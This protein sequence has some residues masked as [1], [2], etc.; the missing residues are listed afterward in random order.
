MFAREPILLAVQK[1]L[2]VRGG[3]HVATG[4]RQRR[5][6]D[7]YL[8]K[9]AQIHAFLGETRRRVQRRKWL[10]QDSTRQREARGA[11]GCDGMRRGGRGRAVRRSAAVQRR[12]A[13]TDTGSGPRTGR[14]G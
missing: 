6:A 4:L 13:A 14:D 8:R 1:C 5:A 7:A 9:T 12:T 2:L 10:S 3:E 11:C